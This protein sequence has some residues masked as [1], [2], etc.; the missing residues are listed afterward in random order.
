L[1]LSKTTAHPEEAYLFAKYM[2]YGKE[3]FMKRMEIAAKEGK[4][5]N[6]L[7]INSDQE[8]LDEYF[9]QLNIPGIRKAYDRLDEA[10]LEPVKT[11]PGYAQSRWNAPTGVKTAE[12]EIGRASCRE[13][14]E[15]TA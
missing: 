11:V 15:V 7:P 12:S 14:G 1:G 9:A 2:S 4:V 6:T 5:V 3:G 10:I 8:I 13:R